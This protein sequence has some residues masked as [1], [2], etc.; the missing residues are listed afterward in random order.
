M[1]LWKLVLGFPLQVIL[2]WLF[3]QTFSRY[4]NLLDCWFLK[5]YVG[6]LLST[7]S[8]PFSA[9]PVCWDIYLAVG[10]V[11]YSWSCFGVCSCKE[12]RKDSSLWTIGFINCVCGRLSVQFVLYFFNSFQLLRRCFSIWIWY[13]DAGPFVMVVPTK[14]CNGFPPFGLLV[15]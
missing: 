4:S 6:G 1:L 8:F 3:L 12:I 7:L 2:W 11:L 10:L 13:S 15:S 9:P 14:N 5:C